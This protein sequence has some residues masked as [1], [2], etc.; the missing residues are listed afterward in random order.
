M[1]LEKYKEKGLS[2][3]LNLGN[4][5]YANSVIQCLNHTYPFIEMLNQET[6][7]INTKNCES[8]LFHE[9]NGLQKLM[10]DKNCIISPKRFL[11]YFLEVAKEKDRENFL[12]YQQNDAGEFLQFLL[13]CFHNSLS[14]EVTINIRGNP[15][16]N[17]DKIAAKCFQAHKSFYEKEY[18]EMIKLFSAIQVS[19]VKH[20]DTN[21]TSSI[22]CEPFMSVVLPIMKLGVSA[23]EKYELSLHDCFESY[24]GKED[25]GSR[26]KFTQFWSFPEILIVILNRFQ[27]DGSRKNQKCVNFDHEQELDLSKYVI[28]YNPKQYKYNLYA[29]CNHT[30][31]MDG[32]HYTSYVKNANGKWYHF[33]DDTIRDIGKNK[34]VSQKAYVLFF[35]KVAQ[36]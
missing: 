34:I 14:R 36:K 7:H 1:E 35:Q 5:C 30:G 20:S 15:K 13:E 16:R 2:G 11:K 19:I 33:N 27:G 3:L 17:Q 21:E 12:Y 18:S 8:K 32:G 26:I 6:H 22:I 25:L 9:Y 4:T 10:W 28:G 24:C 29:V 23:N 31:V